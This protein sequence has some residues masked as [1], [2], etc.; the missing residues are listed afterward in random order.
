MAAWPKPITLRETRGGSDVVHVERG[1]RELQPD[2]ELDAGEPA[3]P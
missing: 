3:A 1:E 2:R